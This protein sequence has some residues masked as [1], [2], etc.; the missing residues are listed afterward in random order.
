M[1]DHPG[2]ELGSEI[3]L[4]EGEKFPPV[5]RNAGNVALPAADM[6]IS[7]VILR[8][9][10]RSSDNF[11]TW[12]NKQ[13]SSPLSNTG[14][15]VRSFFRIGKINQRIGSPESNCKVKSLSESDLSKPKNRTRSSSDSS[16]SLHHEF[17][18]KILDKSKSLCE[19][20]PT[21]LNHEELYEKLASLDDSG[22]FGLGTSKN[23]LE[24]SDEETPGCFGDKKLSEEETGESTAGNSFPFD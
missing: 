7:P 17:C 13:R 11:R 16:E 19:E 8:K 1:E 6:S 20:F 23:E 3:Y 9:E 12:M 14:K 10:S 15:E 18:V 5:V 4:M 24:K 22:A 21:K 2:P